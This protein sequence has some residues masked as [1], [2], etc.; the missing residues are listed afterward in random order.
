MLIKKSIVYSQRLRI[1]RLYLWSLAFEK[2]L[3]SLR[4]WFGKGG[5]PQKLVDNQLTRVVQNRLEQ[6]EH[7]TKHGAGLSQMF[8][9]H[10]GFND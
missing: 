8:T 2:E 6:S 1:I 5:Y 3:E 7:Q 4:F 9:Y 10:L